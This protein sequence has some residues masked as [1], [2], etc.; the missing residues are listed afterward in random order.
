MTR[1][2]IFMHEAI[3]LSQKGMEN[4]EG[5]RFGCIVVKGGEIVGRRNNKVNSTNDPTAHA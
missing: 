3:L 5:G 1:E 4:N 2:E